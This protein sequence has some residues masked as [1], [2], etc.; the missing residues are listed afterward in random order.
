[1][2]RRMSGLWLMLG[3]LGTGV[4]GP[5]RAGERTVVTHVIKVQEERESTRWTLTEWLRIKE[6]MKLMDVWLAMFSQPQQETF[7]PEF[8]LGFHQM[9]SHVNLDGVEQSS[10]RSQS[11]NVQLWL[12]NLITSQTGLRTVNIDWGFELYGRQMQ[13]VDPLGES[14]GSLALA[15]EPYGMAAGATTQYASLNLRLLGDNSQDSSLVLKYGTYESGLGTFDE[16]GAPGY[17]KMGLMGGGELSVYLLK[18]LG[19]E[20]QYLVFGET[21]GFVEPD[22]QQGRSLQY[23][24]FVEVSLLRLMAGRFSEEW[25]DSSR[26]VERREQGYYT[27]IKLQF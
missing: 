16:S 21:A 25:W 12:T 19:G 13:A 3:V 18:W 8:N 9:D 23:G 2:G 17:S 20:G 7:R 4:A 24:G 26:T 14:A 11:A 1:M 15:T 22:H 5:L 27:G 6:R 10:T